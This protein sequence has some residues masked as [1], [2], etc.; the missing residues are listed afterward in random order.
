MNCPPLVFWILWTLMSPPSS[1]GGERIVVGPSLW[2]ATDRWQIDVESFPEK[3][4]A[5]P[6]RF[7]LYAIVANGAAVEGKDGWVL[8]L[9]A[10]DE[11]PDE[12]DFVLHVSIDKKTG[13][14]VKAVE[15]DGEYAAKFITFGDKSVIAPPLELFP[16][17]LFAVAEPG[18]FV[19]GVN[20][21]AITKER[22][23]LQ[24]KVGV[25]FFENDV[26]QWRISQTWKDG[27]LFWNSY[28]RHVKGRLTLKATAK[29][30]QLAK[31]TDAEKK[32]LGETVKSEEKKIPD[33]PPRQ[34]KRLFVLVKIESTRP[35][36]EHVLQ[37]I[38]EAS[39]VH[40]EAVSAL[41][42]HAPDLG[43]IEAGVDAIQLMGLLAKIEIQNAHWEKTATGYRLRG[44][45]TVPQGRVLVTPGLKAAPP[46]AK[47]S[48]PDDPPSEPTPRSFPWFVTL[49]S[50]LALCA[51]ATIAVV[52]IRRRTAA[53]STTAETRTKP[54]S[55]KKPT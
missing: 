1:M 16:A 55:K 45:S 6:P 3:L 28:E 8:T 29:V 38:K 39:G 15:L 17:E 47:V 53:Q 50:V 9:A 26:E 20:K 51:I 13:W 12:T 30:S 7:S 2:K 37:R 10:I 46:A 5:K 43:Y 14:P 27:D 19:A 31:R 18:V 44:I 33:N 40:V 11:L 35:S 32:Q 36:M 22:T 23:G 24:T 54:A 42:G 4:G 21:L 34:D 48:P 49:G 52:L 41:A 25:T